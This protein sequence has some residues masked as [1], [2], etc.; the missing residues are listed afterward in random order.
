MPLEEGRLPA[1]V[2]L[3]DLL[4]HVDERGVLIELWR[5][6]WQRGRAPVQWNAVRSRPGALRGVHVHIRHVDYLTLPIGLAS[7]G[8]RDLRRESPTAGA[9][10]VV[11]LDANTPEALT[12]PPG[13]A[14]GFFFHETS[15]N[16]YA[17]SELFNPAD[18]LGCRFDD[19]EL[20]IPWPTRDVVLSARDHD[21]PPLRT[22]LQELEP[23]QD[24]LFRASP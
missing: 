6:T 4:P 20:G 17:V 10:A 15:M 23:H 14:H 18:E 5:E 3:Y 9:V 1:G 7:I 22:L 11:K 12:I 8:L 24:R 19:T 21:L 2:E 16:C 13:V